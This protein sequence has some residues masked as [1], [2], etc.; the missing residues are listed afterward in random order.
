[1]FDVLSVWLPRVITSF[2]FG[3]TTKKKRHGS[4]LYGL[5]ISVCKAINKDC[6]RVINIAT[7][8]IRLSIYPTNKE[9]R[10]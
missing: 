3:F 1:M 4:L 5:P 7:E 6:V 2:D 8:L 9:T 10:T